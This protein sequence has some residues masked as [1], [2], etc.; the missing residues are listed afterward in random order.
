[1][2]DL[3]LPIVE[4]HTTDLAGCPKLTELRRAGKVD[5]TCPGALYRGALANAALVVIHRDLDFTVEGVDAAMTEAIRVVDEQMKEEGRTYTEAVVKNVIKNA[6][7]VAEL[8]VAYCE[9]F[10]QLF[11]TPIIGTELPVRLE[12][13]RTK[14]ASHL[15]LLFRDP[16]DDQLVI[17]DWKLTQQDPSRAYLARNRQMILYCLA[18]KYGQIMIGDDWIRFDE[19]PVIAWIHLPN[20]AAYKR[21]GTRPTDGSTYVKGELRPL[22][23]VVKRI[24]FR[25]ERAQ[26]MINELVSYAKMLE[27]GIFP[28]IPDPLGY[29][30]CPGQEFCKRYDLPPTEFD[31]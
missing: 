16:G 28:R 8:L 2:T 10:S 17:W 26:D 30:L 23:S 25:E 6:S 11:N 22:D 14:F 31:H 18:A 5:M 21:G 7:E 29:F 24:E 15:D 13:G 3:T 12:H 19:W 27:A 9:R 1:M 4:F 20:L